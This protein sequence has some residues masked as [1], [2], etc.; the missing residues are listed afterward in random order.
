MSF[1]VPSFL[2]AALTE[3]DGII[4]ISIDNSRHILYVLTEKGS[5]EVY[6]LGVA[7]DSLTKVTK[8]NQSSL[9]NQ[10]VHIVK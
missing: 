8:L 2:N 1:L 3:E 10:A 4:Q 9:V 5:I 6:D 7:G